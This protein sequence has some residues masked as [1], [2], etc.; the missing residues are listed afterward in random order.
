MGARPRTLGAAAVPVAVG[1]A[2]SVRPV[3]WHALLAAT[4]ALALQVGV[5]YANDYSDGVRGVDENRTGPLRLTAS[6]LV[7]ARDVRRAAA[8]SLLV[9]AAAGLLL[10]VT[11]APWLIAVGALC[12]AAAVLYSGGSRPY[13]SRALGEVAVFVFFGLVAVAGTAFVN[14]GTVPSRAW[15]AAVSV[16]LLA[17]LLL[18]VNNLRDIPG[19]RASGKRTLAVRLGPAHTRSLY[20][21]VT[22]MAFA[23]VVAGV[24]TRGLPATALLVLLAA[25]LAWSPLL[26]VHR[27]TGRGLVPALLASARLHLVAGALL[28]IGLAVSR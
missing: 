13:A 4:V 15:W 17:T 11:T 6:G 3:W 7:A 8:L 9:A 2:A 25:P 5:N 22:V 16:G 19:D 12:I 10:A 23:V 20:T 24:L 28:T 21:A 27:R 18:I 26:A 1:I 14:G